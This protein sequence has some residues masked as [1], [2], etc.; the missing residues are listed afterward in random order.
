MV[1]TKELTDHFWKIIIIKNKLH[2]TSWKFCSSKQ[3]I[4]GNFNQD[5][6]STITSQNHKTKSPS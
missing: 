2:K 4:N 5:I 6:D 3:K 1:G